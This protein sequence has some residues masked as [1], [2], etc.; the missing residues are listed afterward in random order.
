[1]L[2]SPLGAHL[3]PTPLPLLRTAPL[4]QIRHLT[5]ALISKT[6]LKIV[7][8][9]KV[10]QLHIPALLETHIYIHTD[11]HQRPPVGFLKLSYTDVR[12]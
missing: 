4:V 12:S 1:M 9:E 10:V 6:H 3:T 5:A 8:E 2:L 7:V 11:T